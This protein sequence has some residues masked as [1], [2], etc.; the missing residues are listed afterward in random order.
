M[1]DDLSHTVPESGP[2]PEDEDDLYAAPDP[3]S[4]FLCRSLRLPTSQVGRIQWVNDPADGGAPTVS[5]VIF[6]P[7]ETPALINSKTGE[8]MTGHHMYRWQP[9]EPVRFP[10]EI[11]EEVV[12][13]LGAGSGPLAVLISSIVQCVV[14]TA[15]R[16][17][18]MII[19]HRSAAQWTEPT[20]APQTPP[21]SYTV[22]DGG[23]NEAADCPS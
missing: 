16:R 10:S 2:D 15:Q 4:T 22:S 19:R 11:I 17:G 14:D 13:E 23:T 21:N 18:F 12:D 20:V 6:P 9:I 8:P 7:M 1:S 3:F 5:A